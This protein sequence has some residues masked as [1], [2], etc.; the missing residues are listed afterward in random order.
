M[1]KKYYAPWKKRD[2]R[3]PAR[4]LY[5]YDKEVVTSI[6]EKYGIEERKAI[7]DFLSSETYQMLIDPET[8][9]YK[10]SPLIIF[11]IWEAEKVTGNP[12]QSVYIRP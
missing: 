4:T 7:S 6:I 1:G 11:D 9:L 5:F 2:N 8:E 3:I 10:V 12:R